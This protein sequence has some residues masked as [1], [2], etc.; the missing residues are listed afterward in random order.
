MKN[1]NIQ[2]SPKNQGRKDNRFMVTWLETGSPGN[3]EFSYT[4]ARANEFTYREE[5]NNYAMDLAKYNSSFALQQQVAF[6]KNCCT[7]SKRQ[8]MTEQVR[9]CGRDTRAGQ[10]LDCKKLLRQNIYS[11]AC[12]N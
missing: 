2:V 3:G 7:T 6:C 11:L 9:F 4:A 10:A 5:A 8:T 12:W 1:S